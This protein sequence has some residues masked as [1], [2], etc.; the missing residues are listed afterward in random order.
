MAL[1]LS[2][3]DVRAVLSV[4]DTV[5]ICEE[6]YRLYGIERNVTSNPSTSF[7]TVPDAIPTTLWIKGAH[8]H[9]TGIAGI[10]FGAQFGNFYFAV[11]D[12][13]T[14]MLRGLLEQS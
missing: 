9:S 4:G 2:E 5:A 13:R 10:F 14:G 12:S 7:M 3:T 1:L 11:L 6:A 8:L